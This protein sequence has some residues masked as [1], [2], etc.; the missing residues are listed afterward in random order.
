MP[1]ARVLIRKG[2]LAHTVLWG[3]VLSGFGCTGGAPDAG[4]DGVGGAAGAGAGD[5]CSPELEL[6]L[7]EFREEGAAL[8][9]LQAG[10]PLHLWNAPQGGHVVLVAAEVRGLEHD[11][12]AIEAR[13]L[14]PD[15]EAL[16]KD[17]VRSIVMKPM[18]DEP[19]WMSPDIRSRSQVAHIAMCPDAQRREL[20]DTPLLLEVEIR[21]EIDAECTRTASQRFEVTAGCLQETE[22][23]RDFC[24]CQ[25]APDYMPGA[26][27]L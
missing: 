6:R 20:I 1:G 25:C 8:E 19:D 18:P 9:P 5:P 22:A 14:D 12:V 7:G 13:L 23:E 26:C 3:L 17:D 2:C 21:E 15:T 24:M 4:A 10:A 11:I 16:L 27:S